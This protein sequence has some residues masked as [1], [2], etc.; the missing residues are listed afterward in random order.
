[1]PAASALHF[2][3]AVARDAAAWQVLH[4]RCQKVQQRLRQ[5]RVARFPPMAGRSVQLS[6]AP[7]LC[8]NDATL[9]S[10]AFVAAMVCHPCNCSRLCERRQLRSMLVLCS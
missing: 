7:V 2:S 6:A 10:A 9:V 8:G 1:M 3:L 5:E 4:T